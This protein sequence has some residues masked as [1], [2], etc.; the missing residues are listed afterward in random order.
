MFG[1]LTMI[2]FYLILRQIQCNLGE[3]LNTPWKQVKKSLP[4]DTGFA[5]I[6]VL[7]AMVW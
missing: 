1:K 2:L 5:K 4:F 6:A 3:N 7:K